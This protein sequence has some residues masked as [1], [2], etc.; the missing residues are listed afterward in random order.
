[1]RRNTWTKFGGY[2]APGRLAQRISKN[3][4]WKSLGFLSIRANRNPQAMQWLVFGQHLPV[5]Q[6]LSGVAKALLQLP[7]AQKGGFVWRGL[8]RPC[9]DGALN[10]IEYHWIDCLNFIQHFQV[11][12]MGSED[13]VAAPGLVFTLEPVICDFGH[14]SRATGRVSSWTAWI[15]P[16]HRNDEHR[17]HMQKWLYVDVWHRNLPRVAMTYNHR[18]D[19]TW[20]GA[21]FQWFSCCWAVS[22]SITLAAAQLLGR[23]ISSRPVRSGPGSFWNLPSWKNDHLGFQ[24][25]GIKSHLPNMVFSMPSV[26]ADTSGLVKW[27]LD[28]YTA[29]TLHW[30]KKQTLYD[31]TQSP[32]SNSSIDMTEIESLWLTAVWQWHSQWK[33]VLTPC[34]PAC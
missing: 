19:P 34:K 17:K 33:I 30:W 28:T 14:V 29:Y 11:L 2:S 32:M 3:A 7:G 18:I 25:A 9:A 20:H 10:I 4:R 12:Q 31:L 1:M 16:Y 24:S 5:F 23:R 15:N 13:P 26:L 6:R 22:G 21:R 8:V 27:R